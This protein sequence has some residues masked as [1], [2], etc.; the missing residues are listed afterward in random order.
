MSRLQLLKH[1]DVTGD[2]LGGTKIDSFI[3]G[4]DEEMFEFTLWEISGRMTGFQVHTRDGTG[5]EKILGPFGSHRGRDVYAHENVP[6]PGNV[7]FLSGLWDDQRIIT[8]YFHYNCM[9]P[10][11]NDTVGLVNKVCETFAVENPSG[12]PMNTFN[13][14]NISKHGRITALKVIHGT[15]VNS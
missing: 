12:L 15:Y 11:P 6:I 1:D 10:S 7:L 14:L 3:I 2:L 13:D 4:E 9:R 8:I 5:K